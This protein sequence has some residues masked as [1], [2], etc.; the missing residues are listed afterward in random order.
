MGRLLPSQ[1]GRANCGIAMGRF[2][3]LSILL[4][5]FLC[6]SSC[7]SEN[8]GPGRSLKA[9]DPVPE[10]SVTLS[11]G[12]TV[13]TADMKGHTTVIVFFNT[14]CSDCQR[15]LPKVQ[16]AY[17]RA[18]AEGTDVRFICIAREETDASISAYWE[19][20]GLTLPYSPQ[21]DR[22]IYNLFASQG[23]PRI[24][25]ITPSLSVQPYN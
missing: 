12:E 1:C 3:T 20:E 15:E 10:F 8:D 25:L 24:Y 23:I 14:G 9:G 7:I 21:P 6:L 18:L 13:S 19:A 5:L 17:D 11:T 2:S 16:E 4:G 22:R